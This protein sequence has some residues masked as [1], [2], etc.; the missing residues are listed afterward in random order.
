[1]AEVDCSGTSC[2]YYASAL[3]RCLE[4][5]TQACPSLL[6]DTGPL[7]R[8]HD[9][10]LTLQPDDAKSTEVPTHSQPL[11]LSGALA[12]TAA[13]EKLLGLLEVEGGGRQAETGP[14]M[15]AALASLSA[16]LGAAL[17]REQAH[18]IRGLYVII[19]PEVTGGRDPLDI[20]T[21]AVRGGARMLQLRDKLRDKG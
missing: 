20:A 18:R 7:K 4:S 2:A 10:A 21:A 16:T 13:A 12:T 14:A 17:R 15:L 1:M 5:L 19:D 8:L 11:T 6:D 3:H 9:L